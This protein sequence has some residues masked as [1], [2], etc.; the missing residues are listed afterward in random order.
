MWAMFEESIM[1]EM[2]DFVFQD[3]VG[4]LVERD[5]DLV[6]FEIWIDFVKLF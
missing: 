4:E 2:R 5:K 3:I 6:N 1:R